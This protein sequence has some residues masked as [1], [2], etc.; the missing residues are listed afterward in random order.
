MRFYIVFLSILLW[1]LFPLHGQT[2]EELKQSPTP[3]AERYILLDELTDRVLL[4]KGAHDQV[5]VASITKVMTAVVALEY[6]NLSDS[7]KVSEEAVN[8]NGSSIYLEVGEEITLEDLLY[9]LMLRSGNDA[10]K[11]IAEHIGGS[12][13]GFVYLMNETAAIIGMNNSHFMNPHGLDEDSHYSSAY[14]IAI[15]M[16]YAMQNKQFQNISKTESYHSE[17]RTY[18]WKNKNKLL[19]EKF[20]YTTGGKTGF[21]TQAGR[22]LV[23]TAEKDGEKLI[24]VTLNASDDWNDHTALYDW[25]FATYDM[26]SL[27]RAGERDFIADDTIIRG[28]VPYEILLALNKEEQEKLTNHVELYSQPQKNEQIGLMSYYV[29]PDKPLLKIPIYDVPTK[30]KTF[31]E[32]WVQKWKQLIRSDTG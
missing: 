31:I 17:E 16:Q 3:S 14:D 1:L 18:P 32:K 19:T 30:E 21:T 22:T 5:S 8:T 7:I 10:A 4:E 23:S 28:K 24:A 2:K 11:V 13:E 27:E 12:E 29:N 15:L 9:G 20:A 6:G 26:V 25:G